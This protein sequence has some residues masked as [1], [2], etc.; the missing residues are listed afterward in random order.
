MEHNESGSAE[1]GAGWLAAALGATE[2]VANFAGMVGAFY[3]Q[4][5]MTGVPV[6]VAA[7]LTELFMKTTLDSSRAKQQVS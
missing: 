6:E 2:A 5:V 4:L 1:A 7:R 3:V